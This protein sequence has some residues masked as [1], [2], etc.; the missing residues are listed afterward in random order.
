MQ[1]GFEVLWSM[2]DG[3]GLAVD[4][5]Q[6][7]SSAFKENFQKVKRWCFWSKQDGHMAENLIP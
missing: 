1:A 4:G 2:R 3:Q 7:A 5:H 6:G